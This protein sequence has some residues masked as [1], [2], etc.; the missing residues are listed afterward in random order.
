L[1]FT[2]LLRESVTAHHFARLP[3]IFF[4][5]VTMMVAV[6]IALEKVAPLPRTPCA[7]PAAGSDPA[8]QP[9]HLSFS[10]RQYDT[11]LKLAST[12]ATLMRIVS[13]AE[14]QAALA[15]ATPSSSATTNTTSTL[16]TASVSSF[17]A[18]GSSGASAGAIPFGDS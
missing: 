16:T 12:S 10:P 9:S 2:L 14:N 8:G 11:D 18:G 17:S 7:Q 1:L 3:F 5:L 13:K 6:G 4:S 15:R